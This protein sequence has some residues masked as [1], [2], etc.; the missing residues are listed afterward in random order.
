M[1]LPQVTGEFRLAADP[2]LRFA[3]SGVAVGSFRAVA[4]KPKKTDAGWEDDKE[5]W[6][7]VTCF[8]QLAEN[9]AESLEKGMLVTITGSLETRNYETRE[10]E[11]RTSFD[12][13]AESIA[14]SLR[15]ATAKVTKAARTAGGTGATPAAQGGGGGQAAPAA[16]AAPTGD[17]W[18]ATGAQPDE[19]PF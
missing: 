1:P 18:G 12:L 5:C 6:L 17:P 2:E 8:K 7:N 3:P 11:K 4:S 9:V 19:P 13:I 16:A 10:G 15:F 14:P